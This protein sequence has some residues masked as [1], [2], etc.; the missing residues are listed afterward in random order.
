MRL[1][2]RPLLVTLTL[3]VLCAAPAGAETW[4]ATDAAGDVDRSAHV[5][6]PPPCG[7]TTDTPVPTDTRR[8]V[9]G[10]VVHHRADTVELRLALREVSLDDTETTFGFDVRTPHR[11]YIVDVD[12]YRARRPLTPSLIVK[13]RNL[14]YNEC[15]N[16]IFGAGGVSCPGLR[17][18]ADVRRD[19][20]A[21]SLPRACVGDPRWV[22]VAARAY[23]VTTEGTSR[24]DLFDAW[25]VV[26]P[27]V[28]GAPS[29]PRVRRG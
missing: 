11:A 28:S 29:S 1:R 24:T 6:D 3:L 2:A 26:G 20:V 14:H 15:G 12:R 18:R 17:V 7:T 16:A 22:Q 21:V 23:D 10:L 13:P 8:D 19:R 27:S 25:G 4:R 5:A 9:T